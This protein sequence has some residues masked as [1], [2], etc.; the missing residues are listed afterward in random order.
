MLSLSSSNFGIDCFLPC[1]HWW[2]ILIR[3]AC[4][5]PS[6][7]SL[8]WVTGILYRSHRVHWCLL[9]YDVIV[10]PD[11]YG[12]PSSVAEMIGIIA[13]YCW[14]ASVCRGVLLELE[15]CILVWH[16]CCCTHVALYV[17]HAFMSKNLWVWSWIILTH[18]YLLLGS[19]PFS[20]RAQVSKLMIC[21]I[22]SVLDLLQ[23]FLGLCKIHV[24]W[25]LLCSKWFE[26]FAA[27]SVVDCSRHV[28]LL[29]VRSGL[30]LCS[31]CRL[32]G[33]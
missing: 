14:L 23:R 22:L 24:L 18:K 19:C 17:R 30:L 1:A 4:S 2:R 10:L 25:F 32:L 15:H 6:R 5:D 27:V 20:A 29:W 7:W 33:Y 21:L 11:H 3:I 28:V 13:C 31:L 8:P 26:C 12:S 9:L 16:V